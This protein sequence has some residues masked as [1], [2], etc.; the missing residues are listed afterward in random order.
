MKAFVLDTAR[1]N[2]F[3]WSGLFTGSNVIVSVLQ[4]KFFIRLLHTNSAANPLDVGRQLPG[5]PRGADGFQLDFLLKFLV[6]LQF[7]TDVGKRS[8]LL[9]LGLL[10]RYPSLVVSK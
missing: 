8:D 10:P 1:C 4:S 7:Q 9:H 2:H 5:Q 3:M 6:R